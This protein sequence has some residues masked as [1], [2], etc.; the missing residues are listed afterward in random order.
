MRQILYHNLLKITKNSP[1]DYKI[2]VDPIARSFGHTIGFSLCRMINT[3][4]QGCKIIKVKIHADQV[5]ISDCNADLRTEETLED[6]LLNLQKVNFHVE[7]TLAE[8]QEFRGSISLSKKTRVVSASDIVLEDKA[9]SVSNPDQRLFTYRGRHKLVFSF[10][11]AFGTG[12]ITHAH[13]LEE[14]YFCLDAVFSPIQQ[15]QFSVV[16]SRVGDITDYN[17]LTINILCDPTVNIRDVFGYVVNKLEHQVKDLITTPCLTQHISHEEIES[18]DS[19]IN[20]DIS[21]LHLS[22]RAVNCLRKN[23]INTVGALLKKNINELIKTPNFGSKSLLEII[24]KL[25]ELGYN[26]NK[27]VTA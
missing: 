22:V 21:I 26:L 5:L 2:V 6:I 15:C 20:N 17:K 16:D 27:D 11:I 24:N 14:D 23:S 18:T 1:G 13:A 25:E 12:Y 7:H 9:I 19:I 8:G 10:I 4:F 3:A